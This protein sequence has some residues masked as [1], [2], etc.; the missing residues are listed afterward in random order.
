M[1][2]RKQASADIVLPE[3]ANAGLVD[4]IVE[5][6]YADPRTR[7]AIEAASGGPAADR[8]RYSKFSEL[9]GE[10]PSPGIFVND[11]IGIIT[12][13]LPEGG[14]SAVEAAIA[15]VAE[16]ARV[17][18]GQTYSVDPTMGSASET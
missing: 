13:P 7:A 2:V 3:G 1:M 5:A 6:L 12:V 14:V 17:E 15:D 9:G 18:P 10:P 4:R 16:G 8:R 11:L